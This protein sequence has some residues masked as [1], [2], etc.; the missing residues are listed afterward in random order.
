[1][2]RQNSRLEKLEARS[3]PAKGP[4]VLFVVFVAPDGEESSNLAMVV[5]RGEIWRKEGE[6]KRSF[7]RRAYASYTSD[8]L[9]DDMS[10]D[11]LGTIIASYS[12]D[13]ADEMAVTGTLS[14]ASIERAFD[15]RTP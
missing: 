15:W 8:R 5:G 7:R 1:M 3:G 12:E 11:E 4:N 13:L 14:D 10:D 9:I 6:S 2:S